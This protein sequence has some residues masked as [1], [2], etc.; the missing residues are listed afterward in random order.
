MYIF[1]IQ[2]EETPEI[3]WNYNIYPNFSFQ[4]FQDLQNVQRSGALWLDPVCADF[5]LYY[6][7]VNKEV[8]GTHLKKR[9]KYKHHI[10]VPGA[11]MSRYLT[12]PGAFMSRYLTL[13]NEDKQV[14]PWGKYCFQSANI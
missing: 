9:T 5:F 6:Y 1:D 7:S 3:T 2:S 4:M 14:K 11:F 12:V 13:G 8:Q 10:T